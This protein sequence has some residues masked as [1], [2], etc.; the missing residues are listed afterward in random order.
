MVEKATKNFSDNKVTALLSYIGILVL[1]PLL[2]AK[3]DEFVQF[4]AKQ[5]LV[6]FVAA[7]AVS[8]VGM[9]PILG[10]LVALFG[11]LACLVLAVMGVINVLNG[12]RKQLPLIGQY[13]NKFNI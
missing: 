7:I 2:T 12:E 11:G 6:L 13:A 4:H 9:V 10:W 8:V 5:G 1:I 3:E